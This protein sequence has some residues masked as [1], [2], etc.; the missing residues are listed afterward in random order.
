LQSKG[1]TLEHHRRRI[2]QILDPEYVA[3][4]EE[5]TLDELRARRSTCDDLDGEL[6]YYRRL[7]HA[8]MD[9]LA[10]ELRRRRGEETRTLIEAL[11]DILAD[12]DDGST[13]HYTM[14][15]T[16][17]VDPPDVPM[18]GRRSID[19]VLADDFLAHLPEV[20]D[21]ELEAIQLMLTIAEQGI[22]EQRRSVYEVLETL[23][24]E[25]ARRYTEGIVS[26][27][28]LLDQ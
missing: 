8:R 21:D 13:S 3:D 2:D 25:V 24:R 22:S 17:P 23:N 20:S 28:D 9:L 6:S 26:V 10:F 16:L 11:P 7:L 14:P 27:S 12:S 18:E 15:K 19:K 5:V 1:R 4:L